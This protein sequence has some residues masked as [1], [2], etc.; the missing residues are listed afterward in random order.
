MLIFAR[1]LVDRTRVSRA[2][3]ECALELRRRLAVQPGP[4]AVGA[5]AVRIARDLCCMRKALSEAFGSL[6]SCAA[7]SR[8]PSRDWPGGDCCKA[9]SER[10]FT[11]DELASLKLSGTTPARLRPARANRDGCP[12]SSPTGC[13]LEPADR[14]NAC[15]RYVCRD[16]DAELRERGD[17]AAIAAR[18][19]ELQLAFERFVRLRATRDERGAPDIMMG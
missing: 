13:S 18:Q 19:T 4:G 16:V 14:P 9:P 5:Q 1:Y 3:A 17:R 6:G 15:V 7:C 12:F 11:D 10:L 2:R 8:P